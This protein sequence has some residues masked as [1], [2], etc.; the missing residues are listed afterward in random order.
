MYTPPIY[1]FPIE[2]LPT[3]FY[4]AVVDVH[5]R[6]D[7]PPET[8]T[9]D[10]F[11]IASTTTQQRYKLQGPN[12]NVM[13]TSQNTLSL[14]P[15]ASGKGESYRCLMT[16]PAHFD[17]DESA[18]ALKKISIGDLILQNESYTSLIDRL[19]GH[20]NSVS[21]QLEDGYSFL[22]G[23]MMK[24]DVISYQTQA[25]SGASSIRFGRHR[26]VKHAVEPCLT[27]GLRLPPDLFYDFNKRNKG[28]C[29]KLGLW[30]RSLVFCHDPERFRIQPWYPPDSAHRA[31][32]ESA[33]GSANRLFPQ[34]DIESSSS[35]RRSRTL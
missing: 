33:A 2:K 32:G 13:P 19:D 7:A 34:R 18:L 21:I 6:T 25:W 17:I 28:E 5:R 23:P 8:V 31:K 14:A 3:P 12:G 11:A 16:W 4:E 15:S 10:T 24:P 35:D 22:T 20:H 1:R 9:A 30:G 29:E 27:I 26:N